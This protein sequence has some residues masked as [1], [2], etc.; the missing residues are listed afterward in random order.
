MGSSQKNDTGNSTGRQ[1]QGQ[2]QGQGL[3]CGL[4]PQMAMHQT[5]DIIILN[6]AIYYVSPTVLVPLIGASSVSTLHTQLGM[7]TVDLTS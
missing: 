5:A 7:V 2:G 6:T 3:G 1:E 4:I